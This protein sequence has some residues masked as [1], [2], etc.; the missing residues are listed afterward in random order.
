MGVRISPSFQTVIIN[1]ENDHY[2]K[3]VN[4]GPK[5]QILET[6]KIFWSLSFSIEIILY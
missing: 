4:N 2:T 6:H 3:Y 5:V 1:E